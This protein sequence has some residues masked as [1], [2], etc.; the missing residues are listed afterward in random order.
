M[1][2]RIPIGL[3]LPRTFVTWIDSERGDIPRSR[4]VL[5]LI[6]TGIKGKEKGVA[7]VSS[8]RSLQQ[9]QSPPTQTRRVIK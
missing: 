8:Q 5:K 3:S 2:Q 6:E 4:Y 1:Q 9:Q 7:M